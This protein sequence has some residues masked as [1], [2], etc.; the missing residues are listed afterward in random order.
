MKDSNAWLQQYDCTGNYEQIYKDLKVF[1][2]VDMKVAVQKIVKKYHQPDSTSFCHYV[3]KN[4][5]L[6][7]TC[8]GKHVGFNM[9]ADNILL[10]LTRKV[11][12][13]DFELVINL[14]DWPLVRFGNDVLP[15]FSWCGSDDTI[16]IVMPTYD[17]TE[18][19]LENMGRYYEST[20]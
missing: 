12:M 19:T 5:E 3:I 2:N 9:F 20:D 15:I 8:Y 1:E 16:D 13:P 10:S 4:N 7:R 6:Y 11:M 17:I 18:S 14:G